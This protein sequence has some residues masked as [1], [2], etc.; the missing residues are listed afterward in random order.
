MEKMKRVFNLEYDIRYAPLSYSA[1][2]RE[3]FA[4][5]MVNACLRLYRKEDIDSNGYNAS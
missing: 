1:N 5:N 3:L 4:R 2:S